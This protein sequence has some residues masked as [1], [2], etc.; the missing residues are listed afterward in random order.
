MSPLD[1]FRRAT[2]AMGPFFELGDTWDE[3][4][5]ALRFRE[6]EVGAD[7]FAEK[8]DLTTLQVLNEQ[9]TSLVQKLPKGG[10]QRQALGLVPELVAAGHGLC[11]GGNMVEVAPESTAGASE[12]GKSTVIFI[13][14]GR[15]A[16]WRELNDFLNRRLGLHCVEFD[17]DESAGTW[18]VGHIHE[19]LRSSAFAFIIMTGED[20][21][22]GLEV[23][24]RENVIHELGLCQGHFGLRKAIPLVEEGC[25]KPTNMDGLKVINFPKGDLLS[26]SE[27][28]RGV[29]EREGLLNR[30]GGSEFI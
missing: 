11:K 9:L 22:D 24:A 8:P 20:E 28:I 17:R 14:H 6:I 15:S 30:N 26:R 12:S 21:V 10:G 27:K 5:L 16:V 1:R 25:S 7:L 18:V 19:L 2:R 13:G 29:L 4:L 23:R 3:R